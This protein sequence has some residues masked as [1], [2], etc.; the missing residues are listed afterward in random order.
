MALSGGPTGFLMPM[1]ASGMSSIPPPPGV[2]PIPSFSEPGYEPDLDGG[3]AEL[4]G[5]ADIV[6]GTDV[7]LGGVFCGFGFTVAGLFSFLFFT[8]AESITMASSDITIIVSEDDAGSTSV[9]IIF[10][11]DSGFCEVQDRK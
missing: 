3:G 8:A 11:S 4:L 7:G 10:F 9:A 2:V 5:G 6:L 1:G